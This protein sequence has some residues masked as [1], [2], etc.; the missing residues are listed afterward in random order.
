MF[1]HFETVRVLF[2]QAK[3]QLEGYVVDNLVTSLEQDI[4]ERTAINQPVIMVYG[5]YNAGKSTL[6]NAFLGQELAAVNDIPQTDCVDAYTMGDVTILDTPGIDAPIAH[7][8]IS[9]EQLEK[10]DAVV[11]VLSSDGVLEERATYVEMKNILRAGKPMLIVINNKSGYKPDSVAYLTL[12]DKFI[13][14]LYQHC[15]D[16]E[17]LLARLDKVPV[18]LVNAQ[19]ALKAR[20]ENK[21]ELLKISRFPGLEKAVQRLFY[22]TDSTQIAKTLSVRL[23]GLLQQAINNAQQGSGDKKM[24]ELQALVSDMR[25]SQ[26]MLMQ[27]VIN[28]AAK[29]KSALKLE[30]IQTL[31]EGQTAV[32]P[33]LAQWQENI[34]RYF[35]EQVVRELQRLDA[36]AAAASSLLLKIP[37]VQLGAAVQDLG[38]S[39]S[40]FASLAEV[41]V[42]KS[43]MLDIGEKAKIK[44]MI[45]LMKQG[46]EWFPS[47]FKGI[48]QKTMERIAGKAMPSVGPAISLVMSVW[49]YYK[50]QEIEQRQILQQRHQLETLNQQVSSLVEDLYETLGKS[51]DD[52]LH[53]TLHPMV[54]S[55]LESLEALSGELSSL[56]SDIAAMQGVQQRLQQTF[57]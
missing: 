42:Q 19:A 47:M 1:E 27:K 12:H 52:A 31:Q 14:N 46:K 55:L 17:Q 23:H 7:E 28:H 48:G 30:L 54:S 43:L 35:E 50:A 34:G 45:K 51:V 15:E 4:T 13:R 36:Q 21:P 25:Q 37:D 18:H 38:N 32:E 22:A 6:I 56:H 9:R 24:L 2:A 29:H 8:K 3:P 11:F 40:G 10:S 44:G 57:Y 26:T 53:D 39:G 41:L 49:D 33:V 20:L 5:V 16:D